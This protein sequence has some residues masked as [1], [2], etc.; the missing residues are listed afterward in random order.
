MKNAV[1]YS[2]HSIE[3][4][5][6][7]SS[8]LRQ[9]LYSVVNLRKFNK[10]IDIYVYL[11]DNS[12]L[13]KEHIYKKLNI[14]FK[15]F[16]PLQYV[17]GNEDYD[18]SQN[19]NRLWHRWTN[20]FGTLKEFGYDNVLCIDTDTIFYDD[21]EKLFSIYGNSQT[22]YTKRDNC[23]DIM[24]KL[25]VSDNGLNS[26]Q[27]LFNKS[28]LF[29]EIELFNFMS[30]YI[31]LKLNDVKKTMSSEMYQQ[32]LWVIDQ[33]ALYEYYKSLDIL[34]KTYDICHVMLHLEPWIN[35]TNDLIL[36]HYLNRN[37]MVAVPADFRDKK[38]SESFIDERI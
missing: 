1:I 18:N 32:T 25:N 33:Y 2:V 9:L 37:Y 36:H 8:R 5:F 13:D 26:G 21:V 6:E 22:I 16:T 38:L 23:Y 19:A 12:F 24:E 29:T 31:N 10:D 4:K 14:K 15:Y 27:I 35:S 30:F 7:N 3:E 28:L 11:S 34:I 20:T 17:I